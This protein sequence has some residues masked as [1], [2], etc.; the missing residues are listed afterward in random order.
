M[1][2][3]ACRRVQGVISNPGHRFQGIIFQGIV[4]PGHPPFSSG[5]MCHVMLQSDWSITSQ[6]WNS[7]S[8]WRRG[9]RNWSRGT[10]Q[11]ESYWRNWIA[12]GRHLDR[13]ISS[14]WK[15]SGWNG[16]YR[17]WSSSVS[18]VPAC[19]RQWLVQGLQKL[20]STYH[21]HHLLSSWNRGGA[22]DGA[23]TRTL[24]RPRLVLFDALNSTPSCRSLPT[25]MPWKNI[26]SPAAGPK[27]SSRASFAKLSY[28]CI[29]T[30]LMNR[31][32]PLR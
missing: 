29:Q 14:H 31:N 26:G 12:Q 15:S 13:W 9:K 6:H 3:R 21:F 25:S 10:A 28:R 32:M 27:A 24:Q 22:P 18:Q 19:E 17:Q 2:S 20:W 16:P 4:F 8:N 23:R 5:A 7:L 1:R 30:L 11:H